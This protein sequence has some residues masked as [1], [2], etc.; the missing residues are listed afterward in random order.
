MV[1]ND[2]VIMFIEECTAARKHKDNIHLA[3]M[4]KAYSLQENQPHSFKQMS[5]EK[6]F[7]NSLEFSLQV[8]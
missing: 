3:P 2:T 6:L 1:M 4:A 5:Q 8:F 7:N